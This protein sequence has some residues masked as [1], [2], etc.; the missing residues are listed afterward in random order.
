MP[1]I[2]LTEI[3]CPG[4][5]SWFYDVIIYFYTLFFLTITCRSATENGL[6]YA[7]IMTLIYVAL[8][9]APIVSP[10]V[11][12][13]SAIFFIYYCCGLIVYC[14]NV[15]KLDG[16]EFTERMVHESRAPPFPNFVNKYFRIEEQTAIAYYEQSSSLQAFLIEIRKTHRGEFMAFKDSFL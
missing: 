3:C 7:I 10:I 14:V 1:G 8:L 5:I 2:E 13:I 4:P 16:H 12:G 11:F 6:C 15:K 9:I